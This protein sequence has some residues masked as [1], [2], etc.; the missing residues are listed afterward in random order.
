MRTWRAKVRQMVPKGSQKIAK[1]DQ[2][3]AKGNPK[4]TK[5]EPKDDQNAFKN[6]VREKLRKGSSNPLLFGSVLG[7]CFIKNAL[8]NQ[9]KNLCRKSQEIYAAI[10]P[11]RA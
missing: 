7:A 10:Y 3:G 1:G 9:C 4:G 5:M 11:L 2:K 6:N 8:K